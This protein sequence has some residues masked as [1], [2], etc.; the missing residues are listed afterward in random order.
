[1]LDRN[2]VWDGIN[3]FRYRRRFT[4]LKNLHIDGHGGLIIVGRGK[5]YA[6]NLSVS[7]FHYPVGIYSG[8]G[9]KLVLGNV[10]LNQGV[11]ITCFSKIEI[12]DETLIGEMTDIMD[13]DWHGIDGKPTKMEHISI[14]KHVWI[15]LKCIVLKGVTIGDYSIIG[16]GSVVTHSVPP[17]MIVA[18]NPAKV[19]GTTTT[20]Y[21]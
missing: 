17:N 5:I 16:A 19:I 18:G 9:S 20:G 15:G 14:G 13:T 1:M 2:R 21:V 8:Q 4:A 6:G 3:T 11:G 10:F 12:G 7:A